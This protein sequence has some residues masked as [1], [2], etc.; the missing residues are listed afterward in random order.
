MPGYVIQQPAAGTTVA[1]TPP[2][3]TGPC[4]VTAQVAWRGVSVNPTPDLS[5][6]GTAVPNALSVPPTGSFVSGTLPIVPARTRS[7]SPG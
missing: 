3:G 5:L 1:C 7:T 2:T 4:Q 6:D